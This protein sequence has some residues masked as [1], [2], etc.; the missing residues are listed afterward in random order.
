MNF[1]TKAESGDAQWNEWSV[2]ELHPE[3][4]VRHLSPGLF[5]S[6]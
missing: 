6:S 2:R 3:A 1:D 5:P 4:A